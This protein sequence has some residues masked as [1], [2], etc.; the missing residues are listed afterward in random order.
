MFVQLNRSPEAPPVILIK[1]GTYGDEDEPSAEAW[2]QFNTSGVTTHL[3]PWASIPDYTWLLSGS[4]SQYDLRYVKTAGTHD[5]SSY[6]LANNTWYNL[7]T[8]RKIGLYIADSAGTMND[9]TANVSIKWNANSTI[10]HSNT[11]TFY[12]DGY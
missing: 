11:I 2:L 10:C 1:G 12:A 3:G 9:C 6:G 4:A 8:D 5:L 7:N